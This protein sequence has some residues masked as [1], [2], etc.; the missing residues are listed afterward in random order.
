MVFYP[1]IFL[2]T[3]CLFLALLRDRF[4]FWTTAGVSL[5]VAVLATAA[6]YLAYGLAE[7]PDLRAQVRCGAGTLLY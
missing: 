4:R 2:C 5:G 6:A 3:A 7:G 1:V